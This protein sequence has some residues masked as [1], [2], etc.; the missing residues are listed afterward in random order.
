MEL[1]SKITAM[2]LHKT[3]QLICHVYKIFNIFTTLYS[4]L[5][6]LVFSLSLYVFMEHTQEHLRTKLMNFSGF[7]AWGRTH[8]HSISAKCQIILGFLGFFVGSL[9]FKKWF[10]CRELKKSFMYV[11]SKSEEI[12]LLVWNRHK[13]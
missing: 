4:Y 13:P 2:S 3:C 8:T 6:S 1:V 9:G 5:S 10:W 12:V 11:C 7:Y